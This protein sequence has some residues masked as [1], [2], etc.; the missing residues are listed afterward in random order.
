MSSPVPIAQGELK[1]TPLAHVVMSLYTRGLTGTLAIWP[2]S[3]RGQDR[4]FFQ[5]GV[6]R[7]ARLLAPSAD[8][9]RG[10]LPLFRRAEEPYAFY[11][12]NLLGE[13]AVGGHVEPLALVTASLRGGLREDVAE[14]VL[15]GLGYKQLRVK[16]GT[17]LE[18]FRFLDKELTFI[19]M[20]RSTPM[21]AKTAISTAGDTKIARRVLYMLAIA[22]RLD[23]F[24]VDSDTARRRPRSSSSRLSSAGQ[25]PAPTH[26][27]SSGSMKAVTVSSPPP[28][29]RSSS[30]RGLSGSPNSG[31]PSKP[32]GSGPVKPDNLSPE[33]T[34]RWN[35]VVGYGNR[36]DNQ[37]YFEML[38]VSSNASRDEI[39]RSYYEL[40]KKWHPDRLPPELTPLRETAEVIFDHLTSAERTLTD[41]EARQEY[42]K[43]LQSGGGTPKSD[44][45]MSEV[46]MAAL[47]F[48]KV[49]ILIRRK[50]FGEAARIVGELIEAVPDEA[51]YQSALA[52]ILWKQN[53][54]EAA[55]EVQK[56][57][58]LALRLNPKHERSLMLKA[59]V[60][61]RENKLSEAMPL[62]ERVLAANPK[63][64]DAERQLRLARMRNSSAPGKKKSG[65]FLSGFF[66]SKKK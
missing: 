46:L 21:D 8:L 42:L 25:I 63:N 9:M 27:S 24:D 15:D 50:D 1:R 65:G 6:V 22:D 31:A 32:P 13:D 45:R 16:S 37:N 14:R 23:A 62:L 40:A 59:T 35:E 4:V 17:A 52:T 44:R 66:G 60:L 49:D 53:G 10:L 5:N 47:E 36:I 20:L 2:P 12:E 41:K 43:A 39:S 19:E 58:K 56:Q 57:I 18:R 48:Q 55:E 11:Q 61:M 30:P 29:R 34:L 51:D 26:I 28:P 3:G 33:L 7:G 38:D 64:V 54:L